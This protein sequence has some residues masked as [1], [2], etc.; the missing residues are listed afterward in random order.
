MAGKLTWVQGALGSVLKL[1]TAIFKQVH[2][3][4]KGRSGLP[5]QM[6]TTGSSG[7]TSDE[8]W[9][10]LHCWLSLGPSPVLT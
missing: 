2:M 3:Q 7:Q 4:V 5:F 1:P 9:C 10:I 6:A 8:I